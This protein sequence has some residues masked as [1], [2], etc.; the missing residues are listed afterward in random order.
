VWG[1]CSV[2]SKLSPMDCGYTPWMSN[3]STFIFLMACL[4][5]GMFVAAYAFHLY[6][7]VS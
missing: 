6:L 1:L 5:G 3:T 7:T 4:F 2:L